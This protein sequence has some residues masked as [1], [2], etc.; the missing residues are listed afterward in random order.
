[1]ETQTRCPAE[2][3]RPMVA[4]LKT[5]TLAAR[6]HVT[7][8]PGVTAVAIVRFVEF[9]RRVRYR[10]VPKSMFEAV[11]KK[12]ERQHLPRCNEG[13]RRLIWLPFIKMGWF[14]TS[15]SYCTCYL[16]V[17]CDAIFVVCG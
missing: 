11:P 2:D 12:L 13:M 7:R 10:P 6:R 9:R 17:S 3:K 15:D 1:M 16:A 4:H 5:F 14:V 8:G